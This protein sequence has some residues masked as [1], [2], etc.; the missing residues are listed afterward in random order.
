MDN[1]ETINGLEIF[2]NK[3]KIYFNLNALRST[4]EEKSKAREY[5]TRNTQK[6]KV[7]LEKSKT[8]IELTGRTAPAA[9]SFPFRYNL[10]D[11]MFN[12]EGTPN[13][14]NPNH[15]VDALNKA[16]GTYESGELSTK[17]IDDSN[18]KT[19]NKKETTILTEENLKN[20]SLPQVCQLLSIGAW[21]WVAAGIV[22]IFSLGV[23]LS[24]YITL[25]FDTK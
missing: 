9:G 16:I 1:K 17:L 12:N 21:F 25:L 5:L 4:P 20:L 22:F 14:P 18:L 7:Y 6:I 11:D 23:K 2:R 13:A 10:I 8:P 24:P 19:N 3:V 15:I